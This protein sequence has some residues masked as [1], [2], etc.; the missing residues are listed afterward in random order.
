MWVLGF[1]ECSV[2]WVWVCRLVSGVWI[3]WV[4][5]LVSWCLVSRVVCRCFSRRLSLL[6]RLWI[7]SGI[8]FIVIGCRCCVECCWILVCILCSGVRLWVM[9]N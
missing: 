6:M 3:L 1:F 9:L 8:V 7:F 5:L 2:I 4:V